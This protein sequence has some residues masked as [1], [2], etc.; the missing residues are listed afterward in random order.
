M[1]PVII[2]HSV[3]LRKYRALDATILAEVA[4]TAEHRT[5]NADVTG[6]TPVFGSK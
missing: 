1:E 2:A 4:Q 6:A 3:A 5:C